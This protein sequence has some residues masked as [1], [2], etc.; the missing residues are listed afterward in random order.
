[1]V[2]HTK[3][4]KTLTPILESMQYIIFWQ[5]LLTVLTYAWYVC[6]K[7]SRVNLLQRPE[8]P[9][10]G[11]VLTSSDELQLDLPINPYYDWKM[12]DRSGYINFSITLYTKGLYHLRHSLSYCLCNS[13]VVFCQI[14]QERGGKENC[15]CFRESFVWNKRMF[16]GE[17]EWE[18][19][20]IS[21]FIPFPS[22]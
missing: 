6:S 16:K 12:K 15:W 13:Q 8:I 18:R 9:K 2:S 17:R 7:V 1:M 5:N 20:K 19:R 4:L 21:R 10:W 3:S 11:W 14:F 22:L